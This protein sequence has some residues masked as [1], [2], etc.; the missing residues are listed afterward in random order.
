MKILWIAPTLRWDLTW[1]GT[2]I[3]S[4]C[5]EI[6]KNKGHDVTLIG[7]TDRS[8][9]P[10][11]MVQFMWKIENKLNLLKSFKFL[12]DRS[13]DQI[14][15]KIEEIDPDVIITLWSKSKL[16]KVKSDA[17]I[18][19]W[20]INDPMDIYDN[21]DFAKDCDIVFTQSSGS[22]QIYKDHGVKA[23]WLP[24]ACNPRIH[25]KE[26]VALERDLVYVANY[27]PDR[28]IGYERLL[29][30][31]LNSDL[32]LEV[33]GVGWPK[34]SWY[35]G[36][37]NWDKLRYIYSSSKIALN[38]HREEARL[39]NLSVNMRVFEVLGCGGFL[40]NDNFSGFDEL[41]KSKKGIIVARD[42]NEIIEL[43]Q[44]YLENQDERQKI[45]QS[46]QE[47][48]YKYHTYS[49]RMEKMLNAISN[50]L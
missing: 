9:L 1:A 43:I 20:A 45:A 13:N 25:Y 29:Y 49:H 7:A 41:L 35:K 21:L 47:E 33:Y 32:N 38:I 28:K 42:S 24:M 5:A 4:T 17:K 12:L 8:S 44:Y 36:V 22:V 19:Y 31:I 30:P 27:V 14:I 15:K 23:E 16:I 11:A 40:I 34:K 2:F 18:I 10:P 3:S 48:V 26:D 6:L 39:C 50:I 46:G 37:A